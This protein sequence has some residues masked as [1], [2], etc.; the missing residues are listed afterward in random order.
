MAGVLAQYYSSAHWHN[1]FRYVSDFREEFPAFE[2]VGIFARVLLEAI[3]PV[4]EGMEPLE[5]AMLR[6]YAL[7]PPDEEQ[8]FDAFF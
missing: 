4:C 6:I 7:N 3:Q 1:T 2:A 8:V 5:A